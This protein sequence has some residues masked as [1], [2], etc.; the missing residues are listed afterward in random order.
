MTINHDPDSVVG[1]HKKTGAPVHS[2]LAIT[3][4]EIEYVINETKLD[5]EHNLKALKATSDVQSLKTG[6]G[7]GGSPTGTNKPG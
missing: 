2:T 3:F 1:F 5:S 7:S 6:E 4:Q